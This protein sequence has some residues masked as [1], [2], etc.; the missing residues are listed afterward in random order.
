MGSVTRY[1]PIFPEIGHGTGEERG[2]YRFLD[3]RCFPIFFSSLTKD[4][5][6]G[7]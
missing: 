1:L 7:E 4:I 5:L 2:V 3:E 6:L